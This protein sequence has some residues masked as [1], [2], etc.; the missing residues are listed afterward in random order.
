M[1]S[2]K[3]RLHSMTP[4]EEAVSSGDFP[5]VFAGIKNVFRVGDP[6]HICAGCRRPFNVVRRRRK[7]IRIFPID[8]L[9]P[10]AFSYDICGH[11]YA[12]YHKGGADRDGVLAAVQSYCEG[13]KA[14]Q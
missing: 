14:N 12:L 2:R 8:T 11:C 6:N 1:N 7:A 10:V 4:I 5:A 13:R 3:P 9:V